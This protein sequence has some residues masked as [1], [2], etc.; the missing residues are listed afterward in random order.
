MLTLRHATPDDAP[1]IAAIW[2]PIIRDTVITFNPLERSAE[3]IAAMIAARQGAGRAFLVAEQ[4]GTCLGFASYDQFRPGPGNARSMEH[5]I[6]LAPEAR[7]KGAGRALLAAL[8]DHAR[9]AGHHLMIAAIT[10]SNAASIRFHEVLGYIHV[11]TMPQLGW[12]F[13]KYHDLVLMQK[14]LTPG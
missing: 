7:G 4:D 2:N 8:E 5:T 10:G 6:N 1:A 9:A 11:G 3:E 12:K 14:F 13:G